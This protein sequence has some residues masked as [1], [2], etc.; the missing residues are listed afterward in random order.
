M[1]SCS[2]ANG[3]GPTDGSN[4]NRLYPQSTHEGQTTYGIF[5]PTVSSVSAL[6]DA[7]RALYPSLLRGGTGE[8]SLAVD[9]VDNS[10]GPTKSFPIRC[11]KIDS[12]KE[13]IT[14]TYRALTSYERSSLPV[15]ISNKSS[16]YETV[17]GDSAASYKLNHDSQTSH[18]SY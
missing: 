14:V 10:I 8:Y 11:D 18:K 1:S 9:F 6:T 4:G 17:I 2:F 15:Y 3:A 5:P 7:S 16:P 13:P 12:T